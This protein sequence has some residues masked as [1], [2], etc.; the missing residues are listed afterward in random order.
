MDKN[1]NLN[2]NNQLPP[3]IAFG[4]FE[5]SKEMTSTQNEISY[6]DYNSQKTIY[7]F[8][9]GSDKKVTKSAKNVGSFL[10]PKYKN[11]VD[12]AKEK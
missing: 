9:C 5:E 8:F 12:D 2:I 11:E 3:F 10:F 7:P 1:L 4:A 6:Y